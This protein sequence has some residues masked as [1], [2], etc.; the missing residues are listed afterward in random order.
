MGTNENNSWEIY[1]KIKNILLFKDNYIITDNVF[2][3]T[4]IDTAFKILQNDKIQFRMTNY[5]DFEDKTEGKVVEAF[6][7]LALDKLER[8]NII[9]EEERF[10]LSDIDLS[11]EVVI[12]KTQENGKIINICEIVDC[13]YYITC[14]STIQDDNYMYENYVK[15]INA[16]RKGVCLGFFGAELFFRHNNFISGAFVEGCKILYGHEALDIIYN[17]LKSLLTDQSLKQ[18][19]MSDITIYAIQQMLKTLKWRLKL[20]KYKKENEIRLVLAIPKNPSLEC[21]QLFKEQKVG[22][23]RCMFFNLDKNCLYTISVNKHA[24]KEFDSICEKIRNKGYNI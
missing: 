9:K 24:K 19:R 3:Y 21:A 14:F 16:I 23:K 15:G 12:R 11:T 20:G 4:N 18:Y 1:E 8:E 7:D 17:R 22:S 5:E 2:H 10:Y 13:N 6:Y